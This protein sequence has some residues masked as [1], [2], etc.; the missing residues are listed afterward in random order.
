MQAASRCSIRCEASV[1]ALDSS[2]SVVNTMSAWVADSD[3]GMDLDMDSDMM[4]GS[5]NQRC[6]L[7]TVQHHRVA[8]CCSVAAWNC[9]AIN[10]H[11]LRQGEEVP[12]VFYRFLNDIHQDIRDN[13]VSIMDIA[14][15]TSP[16]KPA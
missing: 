10:E 14:L 11:G 5:E 3:S 12:M 16:T 8:A 1:R 9:T 6:H 4:K 13:P 15:V 7:A 2:G